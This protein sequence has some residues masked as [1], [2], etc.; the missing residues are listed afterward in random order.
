MRQPPLVLSSPCLLGL[1]MNLSDEMSPLILESYSLSYEMNSMYLMTPSACAHYVMRLTRGT[2]TGVN[3]CS[4]RLAFQFIP[5]ITTI[6]L[7]IRSKMQPEILLNLIF[8]RG[9]DDPD[10]RAAE[11]QDVDP[12]DFSGTLPVFW[13]AYPI[14]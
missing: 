10:K 5:T 2:G 13:I 3:H 7:H 8:A 11:D 12:S 1:H 14:Y 6:E 4:S 9:C